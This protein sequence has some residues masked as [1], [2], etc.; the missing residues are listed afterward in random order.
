MTVYRSNE[1]NHIDHPIRSLSTAIFLALPFLQ[2]SLLDLLNF[3][4]EKAKLMI[5][6]KA[7]RYTFR[8]L[9]SLING[10][11]LGS[12]L[13][14]QT[15]PQADSLY[16]K[17]GDYVA[18]SEAYLVLAGYWEAEEQMDSAFH[19]YLYAIKA[20]GQSN[21]ITRALSY[22]EE[23]LEKMDLYPH[24]N[25][26]RSDIYYEKGYCELVIGDRNK[27]VETLTKGMVEE[28]KKQQPDSLKLAS[29][30][31][32]KGLALL[33][34]G[35]VDQGKETVMKAHQMR[36]KLLP[37]DHIELASSANMVYMVFDHLFQYRTA[38]KYIAEAHRIMK[39][40]LEPS[41]PHYAV[42]LNNYSNGPPESRRSFS[43]QRAIIGSHC[44]Q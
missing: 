36:L 41:H 27:C 40:N 34:S 15:L 6:P 31:Q 42:V 22:C 38:D 19:K 10:L 2:V 8:I 4:V 32:Y 24:A 17:S 30:L 5:Y 11:L 20:M 44:I 14:A 23:V 33:Q 25:F 18:A 9:I 29:M 37:T 43:S 35:E 13:H 7:N 12:F 16:F 1:G 28:N 26:Y 21:Q 39:K 3:V